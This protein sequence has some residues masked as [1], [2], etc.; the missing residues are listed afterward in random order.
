MSS[1]EQYSEWYD[2]L[3]KVSLQNPLT[4]HNQEKK[5]QNHSV[6]TKVSLTDNICQTISEKQKKENVGWKDE[7]SSEDLSDSS[8][9]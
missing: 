8:N 2:N 3:R 4:L 5:L 1:L 9:N 7:S 6:E